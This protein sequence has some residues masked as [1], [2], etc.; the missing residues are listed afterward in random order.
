MGDVSPFSRM[1]GWVRGRMVQKSSRL[2]RD[3][4]GTV[5][6]WAKI[7][8]HNQNPGVRPVQPPGLGQ[9]RGRGGWNYPVPG[10][11]AFTECTLSLLK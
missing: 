9:R 4:T 5:A 1:K 6:D 7:N 11:A 8:E 3:C 2:H 10:T